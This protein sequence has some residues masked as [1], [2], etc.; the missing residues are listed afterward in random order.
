MCL[1]VYTY[2]YVYV[3]VCVCVCVYIYIYIYTGVLS[4]HHSKQQNQD[5]RL[6]E[7]KKERRPNSVEEKVSEK[8]K[9]AQL[10]QEI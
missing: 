8:Q 9:A 2:V 7:E 3:Y 4:S 5:L 1:H 10:G 6:G